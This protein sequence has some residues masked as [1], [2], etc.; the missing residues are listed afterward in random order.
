MELSA[1]KMRITDIVAEIDLLGLESE[2]QVWY[3]IWRFLLF[4]KT[5]VL[6][7]H[8]NTGFCSRRLPNQQRHLRRVPR[9]RSVAAQQR[10][11]LNRAALPA[12]HG[13]S[14]SIAHPGFDLRVELL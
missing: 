8:V 12:G 2:A 9:G 4:H 10:C 1:T 6:R 13:R 11:Q 5:P 7:K 3:E 14:S